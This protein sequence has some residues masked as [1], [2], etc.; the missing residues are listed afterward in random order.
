MGTLLCFVLLTYTVV[1]NRQS[2]RERD[3][4]KFESERRFCSHGKLLDALLEEQKQHNRE[5][6]R[7]LARLEQQATRHPPGLVVELRLAPSTVS[8]V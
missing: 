1:Y 3:A 2:E 4:E 5:E 7:L 8:T 6:L